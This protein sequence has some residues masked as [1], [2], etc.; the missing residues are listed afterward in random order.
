M[1]VQLNGEAAMSTMPVAEAPAT[2][3]TPSE[4]IARTSQVEGLDSMPLERLER[5]IG[6]LAA[7]INAATCRWLELVAELERREGWAQWGCRSCA[8]WLSLRCG[9]APGAAREQVRV[10]RHLTELALV[11]EAFATGALSYSK[12]RAITRVAT[13]ENEAELLELALHATAA[14]LERIARG[15]RG[16]ASADLGHANAVDRQRYLSW[17]WDDDGALVIRGRL[18]ADEGALLLRALEAAWDGL[19]TDPEPAPEPACDSAPGQHCSEPLSDV[20]AETSGTTRASRSNADAL[21]AI[22]DASLASPDATRNGGDRYQVVVHTDAA[23]LAGDP[24]GH[25]EIEDGPAL[26]SQTARRA[27]CDAAVVTIAERDGRPLTVGR[28]TRTVPPALRRAL[29]SRDRCCRFPGCT[30]RRF[31]DAHHIEHWADGGHTKLSNLM[32]LCRRHHRL[33]HEGGYAVQRLS[34]GSIRFRRPDGRPIPSTAMH[35]STHPDEIRRRNR[36]AAVP[37]VPET[38]AARSGG[39]RF[40]LDVAVEGLLARDGL[41]ELVSLGRESQEN[42]GTA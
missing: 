13:P 36:R 20:S 16:A 26:P 32:L 11:R 8:D 22:A 29:R 7:H 33:L 28:K 3:G 12:A 1:F 38:P 30:Q 15:Y 35:T 10:A 17:T 37:I 21:V 5:E 24:D 25:S 2:L 41:L 19:A 9:V 31:V 6:E 18:S 14:Q 39:S 42:P 4:P 40:A 34:S 27:A 23:A